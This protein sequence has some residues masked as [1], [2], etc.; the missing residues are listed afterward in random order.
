MAET[1]KL[2]SRYEVVVNG[3]IYS[4]GSS[5]PVSISVAGQNFQQRMACAQNTTVTLLDTTADLADFDFLFIVSDQDVYLELVTDDDASI[6]ERS[7]TVLLAAG[8]P[9]VLGSDN[10]YAN[11]TVNFGGGTIDVITTIRARNLGATTANISI[12]AWT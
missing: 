4:L 12:A 2:T 7:Y 1:I 6:G 10:S 3:V 5:E 8:V 11:Y 9:F